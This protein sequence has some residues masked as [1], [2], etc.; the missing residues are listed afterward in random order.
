MTNR[1]SLN[2]SA[3]GL[4]ETELKVLQVAVVMLKDDDVHCGLLDGA[5]SNGEI[6]FIDLDTD[7]GQ[8][9]F[10]QL[11]ESQVKVVFS[12]DRK[13]AGKNTVS[14]RKPVRVTTLK[15]ILVQ[16]CQQIHEYLSKYQ[17]NGAQ[18]VTLNR[19]AK[20]RSQLNENVF[21]NLFRAKNE[22]LFMRLSCAGHPDVFVNGA[23]KTIFINGG[24][25]EISKYYSRGQGAIV[26]NVLQENE[27][28][29]S[30]QNLTP[31]ALDA[32]LW[33]AG[34]V[35]SNG[36]LLPGQRTDVPVK[37]KA[38]PNFS[39]QGFKPEYFKIAAYMA[40][41]AIS[42]D[43]LSKVTQV[44][45]DIVIDFYNAAFAVD[46]IETH[47]GNARQQVQERQISGDRKTLLGKLA[48][49]LKFA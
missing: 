6:V 35:C 22:G 15:D 34:V 9:I 44:Q 19:E 16:I 13:I 21:Q 14:L 5:N 33:Q 17:Q 10:P 27:F 25:A 7:V 43:E 32:E 20:T 26:A 40:K 28:K 23:E 45:L 38:W 31:H 49:R 12:A 42:I 2:I 1:Q 48:Q 36:K 8:S 18:E 41:Q 46:L 24:Q 39:R 3:P 47:P 11:R 29:S 4:H 30:V 37:L